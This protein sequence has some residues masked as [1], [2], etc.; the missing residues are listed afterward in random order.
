MD[1]KAALVLSLGLALAVPGC[2]GSEGG[3]SGA[4]AT[5]GGGPR[6]EVLASLGENVVLP[7]TRDFV[8]RATELESALTSAAT[9]EG[10]SEEARAAWEEAMNVWQQLEV[11]QFGPAGSRASGVMGGQGLRDRIYSWPET[12][13]CQVDRQTAGDAHDDPDRLAEIPG[14]ALGLEA[15]EY[16]LFNEDSGNA[17]SAL[18]PLNDQGIWNTLNVPQLRLEHAAA[19]AT[20]VRAD[21]IA[22]RD[23]WEPERGDFLSEVTAPGGSGAIYSSA[24]E[25]LNAVS[26]AMFYVDKE[27][28]DMKV[29]QPTGLT[30]CPSEPCRFESRWASRS[31]EHLL[32]NLR[33]FRALF[34]GG[35]DTDA[36]GFDDLLADVGATDVAQ[37]MVTDIDAAIERVEALPG[38]LPEVVASDFATLERAHDALI[39]LA[40]RFEAEVLSALDLEIPNRAAGDND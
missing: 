16:A 3:S 24:Q 2:G 36:L 22:L 32:G 34:V 27:V 4:G 19:L 40:D 15:I 10:V 11:M 14:A 37:D 7:L 1:G 33:G 6:G 35:A 38:P 26:D 5:G 30:A 23:A 29:G 39:V 21:A 25:G 8:A 20:L 9:G 28:K 12:S 18:D 31:R 17:C 13:L